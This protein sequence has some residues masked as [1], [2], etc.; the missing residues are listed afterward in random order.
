V[1]VAPSNRLEAL[2]PL[3]VDLMRALEGLQPK[4][5]VRVGA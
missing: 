3:L 2:E 4:V 1:L 5:L